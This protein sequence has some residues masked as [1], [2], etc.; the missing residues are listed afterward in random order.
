MGG[1]VAGDLA[2]ETAGAAVGLLVARAG[3]PGATQQVMELAEQDVTAWHEVVEQAVTQIH[4]ALSRAA[5]AW[6]TGERIGLDDATQLALSN[7]HTAQELAQ[8]LTEYLH[9][10][11]HAGDADAAGWWW[12]TAYNR[13]PVLTELHAAVFDAQVADDASRAETIA[14]AITLAE[15]LMPRSTVSQGD[16]TRT[17]QTA[18]G[19]ASD[20]SRTAPGEPPARVVEQAT[21]GR[22]EPL[23]YKQAGGRDV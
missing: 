15:G 23:P 16:A 19:T 17:S 6:T 4:I 18:S 22:E 14:T 7:L 10:W 1:Q 5:I 11:P 21:D 20:S 13:G 3:L 2:G 8:H 12:W 9:N